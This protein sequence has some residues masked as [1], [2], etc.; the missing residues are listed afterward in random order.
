M[1]TNT[2][3]PQFLATIRMELGILKNQHQI[4]VKHSKKNQDI[5]LEANL[6]NLSSCNIL[7][8]NLELV[9][10][11]FLNTRTSFIDVLQDEGWYYLEER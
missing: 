8:W 7:R 2:G 9:P 1:K 11:F 5:K 3:F 10:I 6:H 4:D